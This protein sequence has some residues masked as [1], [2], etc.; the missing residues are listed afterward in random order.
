[1]ALRTLKIRR[2][3]RGDLPAPMGATA[4]TYEYKSAEPGV[5]PRQ[6]S[7][8]LQA[9]QWLSRYSCVKMIL[10]RP[11]AAH[12]GMSFAGR[13]SWAYGTSRGGARGHRRSRSAV[14]SARM[15]ARRAVMRDR[16]LGRGTRGIEGLA[17]LDMPP[18]PIRLLPSGLIRH[19][20][21]SDIRTMRRAKQIRLPNAT[22][23]GHF[24]CC[25]FR[26]QVRRRL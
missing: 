10:L 22:N 9:W 12:R 14:I 19:K 16:G 25:K 11:S 8:E 1:M 13:A 17:R 4:G 21:H 15:I 3:N 7:I 2:R 20:Q 24:V 6:D 18:F 23:F 26:S 5:G